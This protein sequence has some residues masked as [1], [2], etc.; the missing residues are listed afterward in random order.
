M[1]RAPHTQTPQPARAD[2]A[3]WSALLAAVAFFVGGAIWGYDPG[4][5]LNALPG[6]IGVALMFATALALALFALALLVGR[7]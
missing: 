3:G 4:A 6:I 2:I 7:R 5:L 1:S